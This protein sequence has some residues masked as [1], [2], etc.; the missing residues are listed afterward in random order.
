MESLGFNAFPR[1]GISGT[2]AFWARRFAYETEVLGAVQ[3]LDF[4]LERERVGFG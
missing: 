3:L 4:W 1:L 2:A